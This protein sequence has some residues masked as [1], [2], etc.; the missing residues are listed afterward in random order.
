[1]QDLE[2]INT[3]QPAVDR[4]ERFLRLPRRSSMLG[5]LFI[6]PALA[7]NIGLFLI[8]LVSVVWIS[9]H[10]WPVLGD[11]PFIG[12]RNYTELLDNSD[13]WSSLLFT[14][15]YTLLVTPAIFIPAI[16]L[17]LLVNERLRGVTFFR[18]VYFT[19][20]V[21]AFVTGS[22][23]W[24]WLYNDVFGL[25]N[26][27]L[28]ELGFIDMPVLWLGTPNMAMFSIVV[29]VVWKTAGLN[30][31]LLLGGLQAIPSDLYEAAAIDGASAWQRFLNITLP[32]LR[33]TFAV[34]L[35]ISVIGSFLAFDQFQ[36]MT[37]GGPGRATTTVVMQIWKT[38]FGFF[39][40]GAGAAM[41]IVLLTILVVFSYLQIRI[42][43]QV[44]E[45]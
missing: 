35:T 9:L 27:I 19:P 2:R 15:K 24:K 33:P 38:S 16:V 40:M 3:G 29:S 30:M 28:L 37:A 43:R 20:Y 31:V 32:L 45:Y 21:I 5:L 22:L 34:V 14:T 7:L 6:A 23:M 44:H 25:F 42:L 11:R 4:P 36:I 41:S 18:A 39:E 12:L 13:F 8:P 17:A 10:E 1:M 26:Y